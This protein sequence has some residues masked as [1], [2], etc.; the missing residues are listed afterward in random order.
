MRL[1]VLE[2]IVEQVRDHALHAVAVA[3]ER[4]V[5]GQLHPQGDAAVFGNGLEQVHGRG[6]ELRE[7]EPAA[8]EARGPGLRLGDVQRDV[9]DLEHAIGVGDRLRG[10][11]AQLFPRRLARQHHLSRCPDAGERAAQVVRERVG[12]LAHAADQRLDPIDHQVERAREP[13]EFGAARL[14]RHPPVER[15]VRDRDRRA[16]DR[17]DPAQR[18]AGE[19]PADRC[20]QQ[21]DGHECHEIGVEKR[22]RELRLL[23]ERLPELQHEPRCDR[24]VTDAHRIVE[25]RQLECFQRGLAV[26]AGL[27]ERNRG[28][29]QSR[30]CRQVRR[31]Q[32]AAVARPQAEVHGLGLL[33]HGLEIHL[34]HD[35]LDAARIHE[36]RELTQVLA[37]VLVGAL[38]QYRQ[39]QQVHDHEC[40]AEACREDARVPEREPQ[41]QRPRPFTRGCGGHSPCR[42]RCGSSALRNRGRPSRAADRSAIPPRW[43]AGRSCS[44]RHAP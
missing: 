8:F 31:R 40:D 39:R 32:A 23:L 7:I 13:I 34:R 17:L 1:G 33:A 22:A 18:A 16:G 35:P 24:R 41:R 3:H 5:I 25:R 6:D 15:A 2:G 28:C 12:H 9:D 11:G 29:G 10:Q 37:Q 38:A 21:H 36:A 30:P 27:R 14:F 44:P 20:A 4:A 43:C 19:K 26:F 42:A